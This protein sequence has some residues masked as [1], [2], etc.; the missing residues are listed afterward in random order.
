M[1]SVRSAILVASLLLVVSLVTSVITMLQTPDSGGLAHDSYGT[2][3]FGYR[4][5]FEVLE[6]LGIPATRSMAPPDAAN[7]AGET[8]ILLGPNPQIVGFEPSYLHGLQSWVEQGGRL[9][10]APR[11]ERM[12]FATTMSELDEPPPTVLEALGLEGVELTSAGSAPEPRRRS[13]SDRLR[14]A[15]EIAR[16]MMDDLSGRQLQLDIVQVAAEDELSTR[17][18]GVTQLAIP[19]QSA[20]G[21]TIED[22]LLPEGRLV[23]FDE[24]DEPQTLVA[25]FARGRGEILVLADPKLFANGLLAKADNSVLAVQLISPAGQA[26]LFDEFYHGLGVRGSPLYLLTRLPYATVA[27]A[28]LVAIAVWTWRKGVVLGPPLDDVRAERRDISEY[29]EAMGRF[30]SADKRGRGRLVEQVRDGVLRQVSDE[31]RL[32]SQNIDVDRIAAAIARRDVR[33]GE[34]LLEATRA[35]DSELTTRRHWSESQTLHAMQRMT[36]CLSKNPTEPSEPNWRRSFS[37]RKT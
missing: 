7:L 15:E 25:R 32:P 37:A 29:I 21:L 34:M 33:R 30:F 9:V 36:I 6:E 3:G 23:W 35:V 10:V 20:M 19:R 24:E 16:E 11:D 22:S 4:G 12:S 13:R 5:L 14:S 1:L 27:I 8:M 18:S 17:L 26:A 31:L 2:R 28:L